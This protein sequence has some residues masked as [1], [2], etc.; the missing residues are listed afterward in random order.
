MQ[1]RLLDIS[2]FLWILGFTRREIG[3]KIMYGEEPDTYGRF[4]FLYAM[5]RGICIFGKWVVFCGKGATSE[6]F[7]EGTWAK[8]SA[9]SI[10]RRFMQESLLS[11]H[12]VVCQS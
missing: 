6:V 7:D 8:A 4:P 12:V 10:E 5:I 11:I 3:Y 9:E 1:E 2:L